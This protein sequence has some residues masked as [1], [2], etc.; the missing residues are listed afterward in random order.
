MIPAVCLDLLR[1][2]RRTVARCG[3]QVQVGELRSRQTER[4]R[5]VGVKEYRRR[6]AAVSQRRP[7]KTVGVGG[8]EPRGVQGKLKP[9]KTGEPGC[10]TQTLKFPPNSQEFQGKLSVSCTFDREQFDDARLPL[11]AFAGRSIL[12]RIEPSMATRTYFENSGMT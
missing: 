9:T 3:R 11:T 1:A 6:W 5:Q 4:W 10:C 12:H 7:T 8:R 2:E